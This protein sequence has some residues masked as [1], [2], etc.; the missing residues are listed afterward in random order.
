MRKPNSEM[1]SNQHITGYME[2]RILVLVYFIILP[3]L[4]LKNRTYACRGGE[5]WDYTEDGDYTE[6]NKPVSWEPGQEATVRSLQGTKADW[7]R[8]EKGVQQGCWLSR[9]VFNLHA[10]HVTWITELDEWQAGIKTARINSN[11][12]RYLDDA[13]VKAKKIFTAQII[14][15]VWSL[16]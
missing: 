6:Q 15:T 12:L 8:A 5:G 2:A 1:L 14:T 7:L 13:T 16:T 4:V 3:W 9:C 11:N 10:E